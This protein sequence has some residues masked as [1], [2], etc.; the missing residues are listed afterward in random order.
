M[1]RLELISFGSGPGKQLFGGAIMINGI[2]TTHFAMHVKVLIDNAGAAEFVSPTYENLGVQ[3]LEV[4]AR[5]INYQIDIYRA[6]KIGAGAAICREYER[7]IAAN[8][9]PADLPVLPDP[10]VYVSRDDTEHVKSIG[11]RIAD[12]KKEPPLLRRRVAQF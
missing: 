8:I 7:G 6:F 9:D 5:R 2:T 1:Q 12:A 4:A 3:H 10:V 11:T